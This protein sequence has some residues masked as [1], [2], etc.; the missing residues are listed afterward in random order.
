VA[1]LRGNI[2]LMHVTRTLRRHARGALAGTIAACGALA[3]VGVAA[4]PVATDATA[5]VASAGT[6]A[7]ATQALRAYLSHG[8]TH[9]GIRV[10]GAQPTVVRGLKQE[11]FLNWSGYVDDNSTGKTYTAVSGSWTQPTITCPKNEDE[12][13]VWWVGLDG[14]TSGTVEQDGTMGFCLKGTPTYYTWWEMFPTNQIQVVSSALKPGDHI[15]ASVKFAANKFTLAVTDSTH[16]ANSFTKS[17][18]C[19]AGQTCKRSSAEWIA[20][21]PSG[22]RGMWPWP[23]FGTWSVTN[24]SATAGTVGGIS[25]FPDDEITIVGS[26]NE[27]LA[28]TGALTAGG[29]AFT[30]KW[31]YVY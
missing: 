15:A 17:A 14:N 7:A 19:G 21:T 2:A 12:L 20:E 9:P 4:I 29:K 11:S 8:G 16:T 23:S 3:L 10:P 13:A 18:A 1:T 5:P 22:N 26:D 6:T 25:S 27:H 30:V 28:N 24:A 31:A